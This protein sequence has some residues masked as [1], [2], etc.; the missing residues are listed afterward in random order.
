MHQQKKPAKSRKKKIHKSAKEA[1]KSMLEKKKS[2]NS[3]I[4]YEAIE[5]IYLP[6]DYFSK[7]IAPGPITDISYD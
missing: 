6:H 3:K 1:T 7:K 2:L 5:S 4:N